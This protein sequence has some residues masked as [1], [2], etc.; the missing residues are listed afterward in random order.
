MDRASE[1]SAI[2]TVRNHSPRQITRVSGILNGPHCIRARTLSANFTIASQLSDSDEQES[3]STLITDPCFWTPALPYLYKIDLQVNWSDGTVF[4]WKQSIGLRRWEVL[5]SSFFQER[6]RVVLRG[7]CIDQPTS[8]QLTSAAQAEIAIIS[9]NLSDVM[10][11]SASEVGANL[12]IDLR[13]EDEQIDTEL[14]RFSWYPAVAGVLLTP[15]SVGY[16]RLPN[17]TKLGSVVG[18]NDV[19]EN[20]SSGDLM[21]VDLQ[22]EETPPVWASQKT[23]PAIAIRKRQEQ[24]EIAEVR[25]HC[26]QLQA[27]LAPDFDLAGYFV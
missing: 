14:R 9:H 25:A 20:H 5:G 18:P 24:V 19:A 1:T 23:K 22:H 16:T 6:R 27:D 13:Q 26:D 3:V 10:L 12:F 8:E 7:A 15:K 2:L 21:V 17:G 4:R 11:A